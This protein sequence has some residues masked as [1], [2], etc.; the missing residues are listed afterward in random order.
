MFCA[1]PECRL[2]R[3]SIAGCCDVEGLESEGVLNLSGVKSIFRCLFFT[4][5]GS[6][7]AAENQKCYPPNSAEP[8]LWPDL[9]SRNLPADR[10]RELFK[11]S[12][13]AEGLRASIVNNRGSFALERFV[14]QRDV[15]WWS[16]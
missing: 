10:V 1:G 13:E 3:T 9:S 16:P 8:C 15:M 2:F 12:E 6:L 14:G 4:E 5:S 11:P 7:R